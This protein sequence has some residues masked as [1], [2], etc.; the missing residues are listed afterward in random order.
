M[1]NSLESSRKWVTMIPLVSKNVVLAC[2]ILTGSIL[3][4]AEVEAQGSNN[5]TNYNF[6]WIAMGVYD[7]GAMPTLGYC[8]NSY[9]SDGYKSLND[10]VCI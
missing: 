5:Q 4:S 2:T 7:T 10:T 8:L 6:G 1:W 9:Y 3:L